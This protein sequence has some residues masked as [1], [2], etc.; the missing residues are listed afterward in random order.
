MSNKYDAG[1]ET[2]ESVSPR[3][4]S[5]ERC[6]ITSNDGNYVEC[7]DLIHN[8]KIHESLNMSAMVVE[9]FIADS[10]NLFTHMN[11]SGNE[12]VELILFRTE[13][14]NNLKEFSLLL[15]IVDITDFSEPTPSA[16]TYTLICMSPHVYHDKEKLLNLP[17]EGTTNSLIENIVKS[18]L[19][20]TVDVRCST[21]NQ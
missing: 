9:I 6:G 16:K 4:Y 18:N 7:K 14:D 11:L 17:F 1:P 5:I 19:K 2:L 10:A 3:A 13:P 12:K 20:T 15:Q 8:I 21:K